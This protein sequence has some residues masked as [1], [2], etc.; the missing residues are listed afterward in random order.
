MTP[1]FNLIDQ[2]W[3]PCIRLDGKRDELS[4]RGVLAQAHELREIRG[5][6]PLET[7][8]LLRLLLAVLHRVGGLQNR[9]EWIEMWKQ[10]RF[11]A[12]FKF[13]THSFNGYFG[14]VE[15][16]PRFDLFDKSHPFFQIA[17]DSV[18]GDPAPLNKLVFHMASDNAALLFEHTPADTENPISLSFS[19]AARALVAAQYFGYGFRDFV[20]APCSKGVT[21]F[22]AGDNVFELLML[23]FYPS[24]HV[25]TSI[26][27]LGNDVP[28][29][30]LVS[31][32]VPTDVPTGM[33]DYLT[34]PNRLM[35]V[36]PDLSGLKVDSA[37]W[38]TGLRLKKEITDPFQHYTARGEKD[39]LSSTTFTKDRA[40]WRDSGALLQLSPDTGRVRK[41]AA[42]NWV[43]GLINQVPELKAKRYRLLAFG[44]CKDKALIFFMRSE[45]LPISA[46]LLTNDDTIAQLSEALTL[47]ERAAGRLR[48]ATFNLARLMLNPKTTDEDTNDERT[49]A[50]LSRTHDKS[51][52]DEAKRVAKLARSW[53]AEERYWG[54][55]EPQFHHFI[56]Q[57]PDQPDEAI[58]AWHAKLRRA[59]KAAFDYAEGCVSGDP[60]ADRA[61]AVAGAQFYGGLKGLFP[62][63]AIAQE[64]ESSEDSDS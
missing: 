50:K 36:F 8:S 34:W 6:T 51:N 7:A 22:I 29:W 45:S 4:L 40:L 25:K 41:I 42:L 44:M 21:F 9:S 2:P 13:S 32:H 55:L 62:K 38:A 20:D 1:S 63:Q 31:P 12:D 5:D 10:R 46:E 48:M 52:D 43:A 60:R 47:A 30:E 23:N 33:L 57:L 3:I 26:P 56:S 28:I 59:A 16:K 37:A 18:L 17:D 14:S 15:L 54:A 11:D 58:E 64:S 19:Q 35:K 61:I 39:D 49:L 27:D 53:N 24:S